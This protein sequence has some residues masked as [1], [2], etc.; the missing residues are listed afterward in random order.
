MSNRNWT[1][2]KRTQRWTFHYGWY[3]G[4]MTSRIELKLMNYLHFNLVE[5]KI[6]I[7]VIQLLLFLLIGFQISNLYALKYQNTFYFCYL[8][9]F[10][11][12]VLQAVWNRE[13]RV[14]NHRTLGLNPG[15]SIS[16]G[17]TVRKWRKPW[18]CVSI[19]KPLRVEEIRGNVHEAP[20]IMGL[21]I[22]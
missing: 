5:K 10:W 17:M 13:W 15:S 18:K 8:K 2:P 3:F 16:T 19:S 14:F 9:K 22:K 11:I 6:N 7:W 20:G 21:V 4:E 12:G 1:P